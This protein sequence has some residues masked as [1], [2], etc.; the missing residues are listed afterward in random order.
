M[1]LSRNLL[2]PLALLATASLGHAAGN[3]LIDVTEGD[4]IIKGDDLDNLILM[5]L[6]PEGALR[7]KG[8]EGTTVNGSSDVEVSG[9]PFDY[10]LLARLGAGDDLLVIAGIDIGD[11]LR[12]DGGAGD[13]TIQLGGVFVDDDLE[14]IT[15]DGDDRVDL[16]A[17]DVGDDLRIQLGSGA[18]TLLALGSSVADR[19]GVQ[20]GRGDDIVQIAGN[21]LDTLAIDLGRGDD[22]L[23]VD[24]GNEIA[25][26]SLFD[27]GPGGDTLADA[28]GSAF[29]EPPV[30]KGFE[31][32]T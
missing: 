3:V 28:Q 13:D 25:G 6:S 29:G 27:G 18:D 26:P 10:D 21:L 16:V 11:D 14:I 4:L 5:D 15:T 30:I 22:L 1:S 9:L 31:F 23:T 20:T 19:A 2:T 7:I 8:L 24:F 12:I 17:T 32:G